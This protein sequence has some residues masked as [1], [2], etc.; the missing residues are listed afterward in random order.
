[1]LAVL[2]V[3]FILGLL[4]FSAAFSRGTPGPFLTWSFYL[5]G[6]AWSTVWVTACWAYL[7]DLTETEQSKTLYG[8]I[9]AGGVMG[10]LVGNVEVW[11]LVEPLGAPALLVGSAVLCAVI[12]LTIWRTEPNSRPSRRHDPAA[13]PYRNPSRKEVQP[14]GGRGQNR[15]DLALPAS[16]MTA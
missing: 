6:D 13:D 4:G 9:G 11:Q 15:D 14:N 3:A 8:F 12:G 10:G 1:M 16:S 7:N 2:C 5:F